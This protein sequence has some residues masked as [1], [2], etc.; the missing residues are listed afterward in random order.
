MIVGVR[1]LRVAVL[2]IVDAIT[3]IIRIR[4]IRI[5]ITIGIQLEFRL[6]LIGRAVLVGD[7]HRNIELLNGV[8]VQLGLVWEGNG[9]LTASLVNLDLVALRIREAL[10]LC[11]LRVFW[12]GCVLARLGEVRGRL[13]LLA[14]DDELALVGRLVDVCV[15]V[16]HRDSDVNVVLRPIRVGHNHR[17]GDLVTRLGILRN[18]HGDLTGVLIDGHAIRGVLTRGE[19]RVLRRRG[20]VAVLVLEG[21]LVHLDVLT[22]LASLTLVLGLVRI[23]LRRLLRIGVVINLVLIF[24]AVAIV[25]VI[26]GVRRSVTISVQLELRGRVVGGTIRV[27]HNNRNVEF[28]NGVLVQLGLVREGDGDLAGVLVDSDHVALRSLEVLWNCELGALR[29]VDLLLGLIAILVDLGKGRSRLRLLTRN[30]KPA[31]VGRSELIRILGH[32]DGPR[33]NIIVARDHNNVV[34]VTLLGLLGDVEGAICDLGLCGLG[35]VNIASPLHLPLGVA[36]LD[37]RRQLRQ[38]AAKLRSH[39]DT[40]CSRLVS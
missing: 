5:T 36:P 16:G 33:G 40:R 19:L 34:D 6:D 22:R 8:L 23:G 24:D 27:G 1:N 14:R 20:R 28:L 11:E 30:Y 17:N 4:D 3:V 39:G 15:L 12:L 13:R 26:L 25:V 18:S 21:R 31:F 10:A 38:L 35:L 32:K 9:D 37:P 29:S 7:R 2:I